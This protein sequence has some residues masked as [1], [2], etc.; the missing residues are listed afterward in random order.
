[1]SLVSDEDSVARNQKKCLTR[2][3]KE[4]FRTDHEDVVMT[5]S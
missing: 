1:M 3:I 4:D 5:R 2:L